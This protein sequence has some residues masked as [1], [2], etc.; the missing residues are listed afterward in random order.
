MAEARSEGRG[1]LGAR[2]AGETSEEQETQVGACD[3]GERSKRASDEG[4]GAHGG[5]KSAAGSGVRC[6]V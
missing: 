4:C 1:R 6:R 5:R 3:K 2:Q